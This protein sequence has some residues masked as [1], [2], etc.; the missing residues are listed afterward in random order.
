MPH[1]S[2]GRPGRVPLQDHALPASAGRAR[3]ASPERVRQ[4]PSAAEL[5]RQGDPAEDVFYLEHGLVKL[6]RSQADGTERIVGLRSS[7]S[8]LG[9]AD[10]IVAVP[11]AATAM[12]VAPSRLTR[13]GAADFIRRLREDP[14]FSWRIHEL[15][16]REL[17]GET[18]HVADLMSV[19]ARE[20]LLQYLRLL[21]P[22]PGS[23][24][25]G[26]GDSNRTAAS[27]LGVGAT[28]RRCRSLPLS[29]AGR[30]R[31]QR[32]DSSDKGGAHSPSP[33]TG[34]NS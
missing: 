20:R 10:A 32:G 30:T 15:H 16:S 27:A 18:L 6:L 2:P 17:Y 7:G 11:L 28:D 24:R 12:T 31:T 8:F 14:A 22:A 34:K 9:A 3:I 25:C 23:D 21:A 13:C 4:Y 33:A 26:W 29:T 5:F 19:S 1:R